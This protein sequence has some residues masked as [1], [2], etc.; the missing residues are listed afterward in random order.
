[1]D[2]IKITRN[3]AILTA[4]F[5]KNSGADF[6]GDGRGL[7]PKNGVYGSLM[8]KDFLMQ[9]RRFNDQENFLGE[10][11]H[12][13]VDKQL[14]PFIAYNPVTWFKGNKQYGLEKTLSLKPHCNHTWFEFMINPEFRNKYSGL[15]LYLPKRYFLDKQTN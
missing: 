12:V 11:Q 6:I 10:I 14:N 4:E 1:M 5:F 7:G 8:A 9:A 2:E 13:F 15:R 3:G